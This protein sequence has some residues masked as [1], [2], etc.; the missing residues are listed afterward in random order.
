MMATQLVS[1]M[2]QSANQPST[3]HDKELLR[4]ARDGSHTAFSELRNIYAPRLY[5]RIL[6]ITKNRED[7]EDALQDTFLRAY[8]GLMSFEGRA[9]FSTWLTK[10]AI[11]SALMKARSRRAKRE[12]SLEPQEAREEGEAYFEI[13]D[14][15]MTPEQFCDQKERFQLIHAAIDRL[16]PK[17]QLPL[18]M[19]MSQKCSAKELAQLLGTS[20]PSVKSRLHRARKQVLE[21]LRRRNY[22]SMSGGRP[23]E[24]VASM[25]RGSTNG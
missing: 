16:D 6:S 17:L 2:M 20:V 4:A 18:R 12:T 5:T 14:R 23:V 10:I 15:A 19:R 24:F 13:E 25:A 11:N 8:R 1:P 7:A 9:Q 3:V 22:S 21:C